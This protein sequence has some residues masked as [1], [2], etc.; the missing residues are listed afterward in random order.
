MD[1]QNLISTL[2][3]RGE[4]DALDFKLQQYEF[5]NSDDDKKS[6]LL[7]DILAFANAWRDGPAYI[8]IGVRDGS[9]DIV[10]L[11]KDIDDSR[12]QQF[13]NSKLNRPLHFSYRSVEYEGNTLGL[14]TI[15]IQER[16]IYATR[17]V[18]KVK[19]DTVYV[20][21]GSSTAEVKPEEIAR[22]GASASRHAHS[23]QFKIRLV[24]LDVDSTPLDSLEQAILDVQ[25]PNDHEIPNHPEPIQSP[26]GTR[27]FSP[28]LGS[29]E[30][31]YR[32]LA[33]YI[34]E[35]CGTVGF[36]IEVQNIGDAYASDVTIR[37]S[38]P[39]AKEFRITDEDGLTEMPNR[40]R[41]FV[42][43]RIKPLYQNPIDTVTFES[44]RGIET[45]ILSLGKI[46]AGETCF[47]TRLYLIH[48]TA[49]LSEIQITVHADQLKAPLELTIPT[50]IQVETREL[51]VAQIKDYAKKLR[52]KEGDTETE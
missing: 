24:K 8:L 48:P 28:L 47:T 15:P 7:K 29:N 40:E 11:D 23:P 35:R 45:A 44:G 41:S 52:S 36:K 27:I 30:N 9:R 19:A 13:V 10:G 26:L 3:Y 42:L 39:S 25:C 2:L 21:R 31:Y 33:G 46:Q 43:P 32:Q 22:M 6:I 16:P 20:R 37:L 38:I 50:S 4:G 34:R 17:N 5:E 49:S 51:S 12:L 18:G 14:Y 1:D